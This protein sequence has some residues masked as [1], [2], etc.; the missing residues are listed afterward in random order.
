MC[1]KIVSQLETAMVPLFCSAKIHLK[2]CYVIFIQ[3]LLRVGATR[4]PQRDWISSLEVSPK[5]FYEFSTHAYKDPVSSVW[6][7][8]Y[9]FR[10]HTFLRSY[11]IFIP[12]QP[13][14]GSFNTTLK[15]CCLEPNTILLWSGQNL[16]QKHYCQLQ[17]DSHMAGIC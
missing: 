15:I 9:I 17:S 12:D 13:G 6:P 1:Q 4:H 8:L 5:C 16:F 11:M 14:I 7:L 3:P 2:L 10:L